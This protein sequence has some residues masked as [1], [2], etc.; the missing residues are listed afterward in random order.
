M[1]DML[2][3]HLQL[4]L[5]VEEHPQNNLCRTRLTS[6][7]GNWGLELHQTSDLSA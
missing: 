6:E 3:N 7:K 2:F 4:H 5:N 1:N